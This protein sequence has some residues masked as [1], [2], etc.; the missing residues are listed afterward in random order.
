M[1]FLVSHINSSVEL[2]PTYARKIFS[3]RVS[4]EIIFA[5]AVEHMT[6]FLGFL[7]IAAKTC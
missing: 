1:D 7:F 6:L 3:Q 4:C 5:S 2:I